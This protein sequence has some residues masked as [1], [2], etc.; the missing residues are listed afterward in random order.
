MRA[1]FNELR[2]ETKRALLRKAGWDP[3]SHDREVFPILNA[4]VA[5][6]IDALD[7][8][9]GAVSLR[10]LNESTRQVT[11]VLNEQ[12]YYR[13]IYQGQPLTEDEVRD[14]IEETLGKTFRIPP[15]LALV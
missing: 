15:R 12:E 10:R 9:Q 2:E 7:V 13:T 4:R 8:G 5:E 11:L 1:E 6:V 3:Q 14:V